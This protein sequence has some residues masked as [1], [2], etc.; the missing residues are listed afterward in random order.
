[1]F[2]QKGQRLF[3]LLNRVFNVATLQLNQHRR[4]I[5][6][7]YQPVTGNTIHYHATVYLSFCKYI[8]LGIQENCLLS[9]FRYLY[10]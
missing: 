6:V 3:D 2:L 8:F 5:F 9:V 7:L 4:D 10:F 1:M